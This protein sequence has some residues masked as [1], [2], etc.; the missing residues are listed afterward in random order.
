MMVDGTSNG[1]P[2]GTNSTSYPALI[3]SSV[4]AAGGAEST[5][6]M[7][8][9]TSLIAIAARSAS[10]MVSKHTNAFTARSSSRLDVV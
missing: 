9:A 10:S 8:R 5:A 1:A 6:G 2:R 7:S 4:N 3:E